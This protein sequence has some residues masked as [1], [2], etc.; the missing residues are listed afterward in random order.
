M[1]IIGA[2][3][4][5]GFDDDP[6]SLKVSI[7]TAGTRIVRSP[8][9]KFSSANL[10]FKFEDISLFRVGFCVSCCSSSRS[11]TSFN[12]KAFL[13]LSSS[14][15]KELILDSISIISL[16]EMFRSSAD[17]A[18]AKLLKISK[19]GINLKLFIF[20]APLGKHIYKL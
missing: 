9:I 7:N 18:K 10:R 20:P 13:S 12:K 14:T 19:N 4:S 5:I 15:D 8:S 17:C 11:F 6:S 3:L 2:V 1:V 16:C